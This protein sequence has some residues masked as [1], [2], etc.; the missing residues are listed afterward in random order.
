MNREEMLDTHGGI[1]AAILV[2]L[3][4]AAGAEIIRDWDNFK[5][6]LQGLPEIRP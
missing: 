5:R 1:W 3:T 2:G 4:I 6:G